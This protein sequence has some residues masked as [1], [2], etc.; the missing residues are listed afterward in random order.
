MANLAHHWRNQTSPCGR[1]G[2]NRS[3]A[4]LPVPLWRRDGRQGHRAYRVE[5]QQRHQRRGGGCGAVD[6]RRQV[7]VVQL[8][9]TLIAGSQLP[10]HDS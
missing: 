2:K 3:S 8:V 7:P 6:S 10:Q 9:G 4:G 1:C 5:C